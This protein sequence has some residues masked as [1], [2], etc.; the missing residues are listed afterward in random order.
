MWHCRTY[1]RDALQ[2]LCAELGL[3]WVRPLWFS[4]L[5]ARLRLGGII[6]E[7]RRD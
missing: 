6:V 1:N 7:L 2:R 3:H 5:H 4:P